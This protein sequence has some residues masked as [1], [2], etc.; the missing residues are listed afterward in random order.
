MSIK[1]II[2]KFILVTVL[3]VVTA[4]GTGVVAQQIGFDIGPVVYA[5][6]NGGGGGC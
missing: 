6:S 1:K 5:C 4:V 3:T 2:A